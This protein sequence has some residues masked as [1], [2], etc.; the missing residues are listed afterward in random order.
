MKFALYV[1]TLVAVACASKKRPNIVWFLTDDQDQVLGA[2]F[3]NVGGATPMPKTK[4]LMEEQ[5][6]T[7]TNWYI[8]TPICSPSRSE[9][10]TGQYFHNIK[11]VGKNPVSGGKSYCDGMHVNY[12]HVNANTFAKVLKEEGDYTVG[13]FGKY[14]NEMPKEVPPGFDAWMANGG[15]NY[16]AP[17]FMTS[18]LSDLGMEDGMWHGGV[19]NYTT[20][21][22]GN[23]SI[24]W[25]KKV[26]AQGKP[27]MAYI[28]PKAAHEPFIPAPWHLDHWDPSWPSH[29]PRT[30]NWNI[31]AELRKNHHGNIATEPM[32]SEASSKVITDIFKNRWRTL[33]SVDDV[34]GEVIESVDSLG[35]L[36]NTY[37]FY[38][39]DHGFQL[40]QFNIPMD[41]RHVYEWDTKIHLLARGPGI[42][43]AST[44]SA[45]GTQ[46]DI[47]PT[48]L[49]LAGIP[50]TGAMDGRSIVPFLVTAPQDSAPS[51][52]THLEA[53]GDVEAYR[54]KW[55]KQVFIEYYYCQTN[56]K[57]MKSCTK[58]GDYPAG[59][60]ECGDLKDNKQCWSPLCFT[61][62]YDTET[63]ANNFIALRNLSPGDNTL[64][65]EF[66]TGDLSSGDVDFA[67]VDFKEYYDMEKDPWQMNNLANH[68]SQAKL[69][70]MHGMLHRWF[71]CAGDQCP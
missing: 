39:S 13:M 49:G 50:A 45:P 30:P 71:K 69:E 5:G 29:E 34:I 35:L 20:A 47:A 37:F 36:D 15:G 70:S 66:Q 64:Y 52:Q 27:F 44:F 2:S 14:V 1:A 17:S 23:M 33:M 38:S 19:D 65:A 24:A 9:L 61:N 18:G 55:R 62:C 32:I 28:A 63:P 7:A 8:H 59:D 57:C 10:L 3:P 4:R 25:I 22:V 41:K 31:S 51:T 26:A 60:T 43:P 16:I 40:G 58:P 48:F 46:V 12:T 42:Q 68:T 67:G 54:S 56:A 53:L 11:L 6:A 21:V